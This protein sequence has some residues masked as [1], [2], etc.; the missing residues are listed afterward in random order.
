MTIAADVDELYDTPDDEDPFAF[1]QRVLGDHVGEPGTS[2]RTRR[3]RFIEGLSAWLH[4]A[5]PRR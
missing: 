3:E 4:E 2:Q 1:K 5:L